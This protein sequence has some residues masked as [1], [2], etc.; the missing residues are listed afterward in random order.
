MGDEPWHLDKR[1]PVALIFA[2]IVQ[3]TGLISGGLWFAA[4]LESSI[5][6]VDARVTATDRDL[7]RLSGQVQNMLSAANHQAVQL[8]RIEEGLVSI[9]ESQAQMMRL[10]ERRP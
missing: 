10:L 1:V 3:F 6:A 5:D 9:R 4:K 7:D 8:G 2:I